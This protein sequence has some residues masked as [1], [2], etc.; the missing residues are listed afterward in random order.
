[1]GVST[2]LALKYLRPKRSVA[3]V[4][5]V[6][7]VLGVLLGVAVVVIVRS[8]MTGFGDVWREKILEFKP[9]VTIQGPGGGY[10]TGEDGVADSLRRIPGVVSVNPEIMTRVMLSS[11]DRVLAPDRKSVV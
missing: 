9:H 7:S 3:S 6:V 10:F 8:V 11:R 5:T 1:M 2:F 4:I